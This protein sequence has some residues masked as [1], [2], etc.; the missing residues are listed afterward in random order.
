MPLSRSGLRH[1][2]FFLVLELTIII[3]LC[4]CFQQVVGTGKKQTAE[5]RLSDFRKIFS[6]RGLSC[7][8]LCKQNDG[9]EERHDHE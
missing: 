9:E 1:P 2:A 8:D 3:N 5:E 4:R 7:I 6:I